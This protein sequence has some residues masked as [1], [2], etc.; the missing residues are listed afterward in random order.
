MSARLGNTSAGHHVCP[1]ET[2][3]KDQKTVC[4]VHYAHL[5]QSTIWILP[6]MAASLMVNAFLPVRVDVLRLQAKVLYVDA[7]W[8]MAQ[9]RYLVAWFY[10]Q[11]PMVDEV[12]Q[13]VRMHCVPLCI[14]E[15]GLDNAV[16]HTSL[17]HTALPNVATI[18]ISL[19]FCI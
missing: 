6:T 11:N 5:T 15:L 10:S 7:E 1:R 16:P 9:V 13:P 17:L 18:G 2:L 19:A 3:G 14:R 8:R 4:T 12:Q